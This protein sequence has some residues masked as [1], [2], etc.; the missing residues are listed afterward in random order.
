M[1]FGITLKEELTLMINWIIR[2]KNYR[3]WLAMT[4]TLTIFFMLLPFYLLGLFGELLSWSANSVLN[5]D[6][7]KLVKRLVRWVEEND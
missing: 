2:A 1:G 4:I 3:Y 7:P 5:S 6:T